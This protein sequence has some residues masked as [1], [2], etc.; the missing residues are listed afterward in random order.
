MTIFPLVILALVQGITEFLPISSSGHLVLV[1]SIFGDSAGWQNHLVL[2]VAVHVGTLLSVIVYFRKDVMAMLCGALGWAKGDFKSSGSRLTTHLLIASIPVIVVGF[3]LNMFQPEWILLLNIMAVTTLIFGIL[4]WIA[5]RSPE[6][7]KTQEDMNIKD[8]L[9]IGCA[10]ALALI[11]GTS[12]SGIT[13]TAARFLGYTRTESAHFSLL[14]AIIAIA[15]AGTMGG[16][17]L[18][19]EGSAT[20][21]LEALVAGTIA[22]IAGWVSITLMMKWLEK[23][24]FAPFAIYRIILGLALLVIINW[25]MIYEFFAPLFV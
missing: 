10:Q 7:N 8:V 24:S 5:D 13:M 6:Q 25:E 17:K 18:M 15:G 16:A 1:H 23:C 19:Q 22:F 2:D 4:L 12:R 3:I 14:L 9:I 21:G 20:L 11:P